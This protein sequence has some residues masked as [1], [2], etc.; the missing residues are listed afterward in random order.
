[1]RKAV[2]V[3]AIAVFGLN[4]SV[5]ADLVIDNYQT[6]TP[7]VQLGAGTATRTTAGSGI[8]GGQREESLTVRD[9]GG[10]GFFGIAGFG[11]GGVSVA[12]AVND[13]ITGSFTYDNF[14]SIDFT[15]NGYNRFRLH[16]SGSNSPTPVPGVI[17]VTVTSGANSSTVFADLPPTSALPN[18]SY[19]F[20]SEF[21]G[22][23]FANVDSVSFGFDF[24][25]NPGRSFAL[26]R[27]NLTAIPEPSLTGLAALLIGVVCLRRRRRLA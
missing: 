6:G 10:L 3:F 9:L 26:Q 19:V 14:S 17:S 4:D 12:Q 24:A 23:D 27:F 18:S 1:M 20:F 2:F 22:V 7:L 16:F 13:Q 15:S 11:P 5:R 25:G 8:L 21:S